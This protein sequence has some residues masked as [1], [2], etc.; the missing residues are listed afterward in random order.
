VCGEVCFQL[1]ETLFVEDHMQ[2]KSALECV[3]PTLSVLIAS[4]ARAP[5]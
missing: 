3:E 4:I 1:L 5:A 2:D